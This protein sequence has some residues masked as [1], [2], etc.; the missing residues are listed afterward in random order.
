M[1]VMEEKD[2]VTKLQEML[3]DT[4][5]MTPWENIEVGKV[6]HLPRLGKIKRM[7]ILIE[8][9]DETTATYKVLGNTKDEQFTMHKTSV[10]AR[11][12]VIP[13]GF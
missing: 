4:P 11:V 7:N 12:A 6:Y 9:K 3:E 13:K 10:F 8:E 1:L 2:E 5:R